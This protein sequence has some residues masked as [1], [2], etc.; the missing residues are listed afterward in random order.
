MSTAFSADIS[1]QRIEV[2]VVP[3]THYSP[4]VLSVR[5]QTGTVQL[6]AEP[7]QLAE[8]EYA[9]RTYLESIRYSETPDQQMILHAECISAIEEAIA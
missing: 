1:G 6:H 4:L 7:E 2:E 8:V 3:P 5:G 9:I